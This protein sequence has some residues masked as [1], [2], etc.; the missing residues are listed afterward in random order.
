MCV[1]NSLTLTL[2]AKQERNVSM[3]VNKAHTNT[4]SVKRGTTSACIC[5]S[6]I[7]EMQ[8]EKRKKKN[9]HISPEEERVGKQ[10]RDR[11]GYG[12]T[13]NF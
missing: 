8:C 1:S 4:H 12:P 5:N 13:A 2:M 11:N 3:Y 10:A 7:F 9:V 6:C